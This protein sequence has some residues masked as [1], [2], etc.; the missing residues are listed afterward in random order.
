MPTSDNADTS[1]YLVRKPIAFLFA[2]AG[3]GLLILGAP[4]V[5][6]PNDPVH[7]WRLAGG[8][9]MAVLTLPSAV[10]KIRK[11]PADRMAVAEGR[12]RLARAEGA[13]ADA[14]RR[15]HGTGG[16]VT[17]GG[18]LTHSSDPLARQAP[19]DQTAWPTA[20]EG[21]RRA[22]LGLPELW[23]ATHARL[24]LYHQIAT[25]QAKTSFRN[26]QVAMVAGFL[27]L[28]VFAGIALWASTTAVAIVA[29]GLGAVSAALAGYVAKTFIRSQ[30]AAAT[31]LRSY[32]DQPL[33][34]SRY[35]AAERLVADGGLTQEQRGEILS[36][37]VQAMVAGPQPPAPP[38][39][40]VPVP[41]QP[42]A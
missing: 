1:E 42:G 2:V 36:A 25:G 10:A 23:E 29:G 33:E 14:I 40:V 17:V 41:G 15:E 13:L 27:L 21:G 24:D 31:H 30:E 12:Q 35:L 16:D 8:A 22:S 37:L 5:I 9:A 39:A 6:W 34:L 38:Q 19:E 32:F 4:A 3:I 26:A 18:S 7:W 11:R 28:V 20:G